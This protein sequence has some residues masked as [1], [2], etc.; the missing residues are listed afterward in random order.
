MVWPFARHS[1]PQSSVGTITERGPF[2][3][4]RFAFKLFR[5]LV[6]A[7]DTPNVFCSPYSVMLCL[8]MVWDGATGETREAMAKTLEIG[9]DPDGCQRFLKAALDISGPGLALAI[10]NSLWCDE[11]ARMLP[12]FLTMAREKYAAEVVSLPFQS[13]DAVSRINAWVAEKTRGKIGSIIDALD[14]SGLLVALN[15]IYFKGLWKAP[16]EKSFTREERFFT[17]GNYSIK[18]P[19]M[20]RSGYYPYHEE[21][22]FQAVRLPY[23]G[24]RVGM[25]IF[26]PSKR[27]GLPGFM[28]TLTSTEWGHWMWGFTETD[29]LVGLPRFKFEHCVNLNPILASLGMSEVFDP[30]RAL[31][32]GISL[33]PPRLYIGQAIHR[34][35]VEVNEEGTEAAAATAFAF[36]SAARHSPKPR[37]FQMI[38]DRPFFFAIRD[39]HSNMILFMGAVND[40]TLV[41]S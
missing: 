30:E 20:R 27:S 37:V 33:P 4:D 40:P 29:G 14:S 26:L 22:G 7:N 9:E 15:A 13:P 24:N 41:S 39:D 28:H 1:H 16:F 19:L 2:L 31:F 5:E 23:Q 25:Y 34:A 12:A 10:A 6:R 8:M 17:P 3:P 11:Q 35:L 18:V 38:L 36:D 21:S 32:D